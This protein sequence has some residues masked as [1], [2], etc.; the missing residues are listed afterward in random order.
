MYERRQ[1]NCPQ[2]RMFPFGG[3]AFKT[4][5]RI[6]ANRKKIGDEHD[7]L[8]EQMEK[9]K[10]QLKKAKTEKD[11]MDRLS[12]PHMLQITS[13]GV[14][15]EVAQ[16]ALEANDQN[17][18]LATTSALDTTAKQAMEAEEKKRMAQKEALRVFNTQWHDL[19]TGIEG[20]KLYKIQVVVKNGDETIE[21]FQKTKLVREYNVPFSSS[22]I[23]EIHNHS[24]DEL[25]FMGKYI[26]Y[27]ADHPTAEFMETLRVQ[28]AHSVMLWHMT[29]YAAG[30][31]KGDEF[32]LV[33][34]ASCKDILRIRL[35][36][37]PS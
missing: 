8:L 34:D 4:L 28:P 11:A 37:T 36:P 27:E 9:I 17:L 30:D 33:D 29:Q 23:V 6:M 12:K 10:R 35:K 5:M 13:L 18:E 25:T 32:V 14:S 22:I 7:A 21:V 16:E 3:D 26:D 24:K 20:S 2:C 31:F 15:H 1:A 19:K